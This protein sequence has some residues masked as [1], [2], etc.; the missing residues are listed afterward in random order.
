MN[1]DM[2]KH[3]SEPTIQRIIVAI[4]ASLHSQA[5][6]K[7]AADLAARLEAELVGIFVEDENLLRMANLPF[8]QEVRLYSTNVATCSRENIRRQLKAQARKAERLVA[9]AAR[10]AGVSASFHVARGQVEAELLAAGE[11]TDLITIGRLGHSHNQ[12][13]QL[14]STAETLLRKAP[15]PVMVLRRGVRLRPS[16]FVLYDGSEAAD[17]SLAMAAE[18]TRRTEYTP[19]SVINVADDPAHARPLE[20]QALE[21]IRPFNVHVSFHSIGRLSPHRLVHLIE[22]HQGGLAIVPASL[23]DD[24]LPQFRRLLTALDCPVVFTR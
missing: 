18:I 5:A 4:D 24:S 3:P 23:L 6:L 19:V 15:Y 9:A 14:G 20:K 13:K 16:V 12:A 2:S 22:T 10:R 8:T 17:R 1:R 11:A 7:A 21:V